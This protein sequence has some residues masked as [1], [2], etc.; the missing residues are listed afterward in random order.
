MGSQLHFN[1]P[2]N[3]LGHHTLRSFREGVIVL[4]QLVKDRTAIG[5]VVPHRWSHRHQF[6]LICPYPETW[7]GDGIRPQFQ[8]ELPPRVVAGSEKETG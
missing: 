4:D 5:L 6:I 7:I 3:V 2:T 1:L 8:E